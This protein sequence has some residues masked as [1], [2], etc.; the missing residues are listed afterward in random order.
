VLWVDFALVTFAAS[1]FVGIGLLT[2]MAKKL[3]VIGPA[4]PDVQ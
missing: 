1:F 2:P 4:T 3:A